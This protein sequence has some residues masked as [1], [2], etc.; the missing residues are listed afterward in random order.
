MPTCKHRDERSILVTDA[1]VTSVDPPYHHPNLVAGVAGISMPVVGPGQDAYIAVNGV[2]ELGGILN[3]DGELRALAPLPHPP[4]WFGPRH[5]TDNTA[6]L[7]TDASDV[8]QFGQTYTTDATLAA[9]VY[10]VCY[11]TAASA[12][13]ANQ[14]YVAQRV[15]TVVAAAVSSFTVD[16]AVAGEAAAAVDATI[17]TDAPDDD[18]VALVPASTATNCQGAPQPPTAS[19]SPGLKLCCSPQQ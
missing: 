8:A 1:L 6:L 17:S 2:Q 18:F 14:D 9:G 15:V 16:N 11:A 13:N 5:R 12:G 10:L 7:S 19:R 3:C 4:H